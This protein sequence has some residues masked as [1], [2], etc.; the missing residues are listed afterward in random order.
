MSMK[1]FTY[2]ATPWGVDAPGWSIFQSTEGLAPAVARNFRSYYAY[3]NLEGGERS[4][5]KLM[6]AGRENHGQAILSQGCDCGLRW[7]D[8]K[9]GANYFSHVYLGDAE[10]AMAGLGTD[11]NPMAWYGARCFQEAFPEE[12]KAEA[13]RKDRRE[14]PPPL[15]EVAGLAT[16]ETNPEFG[17]EAVFS[18]AEWCDWGKIGALVEWMHRRVNGGEAQALAFDARMSA[19]VDAMA[20]ALRLL[21]LPERK[22]AVFS[23]WM[24]NTEKGAFPDG[25]K[26]LFYGTV[27]EG[28]A[29]ADTGVYGAVRGG[30]LAFKGREDA[31]VF[32]RMVD[33]CGE[34]LGA[35]DWEG[36]VACWEVAT[37]RVERP[38][39]LRSAVAFA[40]RF[41][42]LD[43]EV[44]EGLARAFKESGVEGDGGRAVVLA[45]WFELGMAAFGDVA[46]GICAEC[47]GDE[48]LFE[49]ALRVLEGDGPKGA[50]LDETYEQ[51]KGRA[52]LPG[53]AAM[54]L[55]SGAETKRLVPGGGKERPFG[56]FTALVDRFAGIRGTVGQGMVGGGNAAG[57]LAEAER[58]ADV[59]GEDFEGMEA[60]L[61]GLRY[62]LA[63]EKVKGIGD[64]QAFAAEANRLG[65]EKGRIREDG[66]KK[67]PLGR[68]PADQLEVSVSAFGAIGV[69][70]REIIAG[71]PDDR[72]LGALD[73]LV[74][75]GADRDEII[76]RALAATEK[77]AEK[78]GY[79]RGW[80]EAQ[81]RAEEEA[82]DRNRGHVW[83]VLKRILIVAALMVL[84]FAAGYGLRCLTGKAGEGTAE[85]MEAGGEGFPGAVTEGGMAEKTS[86]VQP[87][88]G[89]SSTPVPPRKGPA[90]G[91]LAPPVTEQERVGGSAEYGQGAER[92]ES[93]K[94]PEGRGAP[95][96]VQVG[97]RYPSSARSLGGSDAATGFKTERV[98]PPVP[99]A[100]PESGERIGGA[101][102]AGGIPAGAGESAVAGKGVGESD[103][104][105]SREVREAAGE[106]N[107]HGKGRMPKTAGKTSPG[108]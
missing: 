15:P 7:W 32:K 22:R 50:F 46:K 83:V 11:F 63:L 20:L 54:W 18:R 89:P 48:V 72:L 79:E 108:E 104:A 107:P 86:A 14:L 70:A 87:T 29:D 106:D 19:G 82:R 4:P 85:G 93:Q 41:P 21:P 55:G 62:L 91:G 67:V 1:Q 71:V 99:E 47:A 33:G 92:V 97:G 52:G 12:L 77:G 43:G 25:E 42:G 59:L 16:L 6:F 58:A 37:G 53:L 81:R 2:T 66:L 94:R 10:E 73:A 88:D 9:R 103:G 75:I 65:V 57:M 8:T 36:L 23:T 51:A 61:N 98:A 27:Q 105:R 64:L 17:D 95:S 102:S 40:K 35:G 26:L 13:E 5:R 68:I 78:R 28:E 45:A 74:G 100:I 3:E 69:T 39:A 84:C 56:R 60:T 101:V 49:G 38:E 34:R 90:S 31:E 24:T 96:S 30:R 80:R 44:S 76:R